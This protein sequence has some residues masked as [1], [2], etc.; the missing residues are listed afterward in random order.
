[1][2]LRHLYSNAKEPTAP[3][4]QVGDIV[5]TTG[6]IRMPGYSFNID[7]KTY[8]DRII[9]QNGFTEDQ[10]TIQPAVFGVIIDEPDHGVV[11]HDCSTMPGTTFNGL[12][13]GA[14]I[15]YG[16]DDPTTEAVIDIPGSGSIWFLPDNERRYFVKWI[17][18][19][20]YAR[21]NPPTQFEPMRSHHGAPLFNIGLMPENYIYKAPNFVHILR[22]KVQKRIQVQNVLLH[23]LQ[24]DE[25]STRGISSI[26]C[27]F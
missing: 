20:P 4:F 25:C 8:A 22:Y 3:R 14:H 6:V 24:I 18:K 17:N 19:A 12:P 16:V 2:T 1:M 13:L 5:Y 26:V 7:N 11:I 9:A 21:S 15:W 10:V 27:M 23:H